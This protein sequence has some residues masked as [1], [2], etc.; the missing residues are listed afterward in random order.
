MGRRDSI[1][2]GDAV[3]SAVGGAAGVPVEV[4]VIAG[5]EATTNGKEKRSNDEKLFIKVVV[6]NDE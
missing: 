5:E 4:A 2:V 1:V 3:G 6:H